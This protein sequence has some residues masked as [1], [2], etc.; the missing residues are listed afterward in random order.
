MRTL[1]YTVMAHMCGTDA[2]QPSGSEKRATTSSYM[3]TVPSSSL[4]HC[5]T[6]SGQCHGCDSKIRCK[7]LLLLALSATM[8]MYFEADVLASI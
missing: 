3:G 4:K 2:S 8:N 5:S 6:P 7:G 1:L